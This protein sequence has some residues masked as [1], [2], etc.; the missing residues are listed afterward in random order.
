[1]VTQETII[2]LALFV[3]AVLM[4]GFFAFIYSLKR[5]SYLLLWTAG[6]GLLGLHSLSPVF[7]PWVGLPSWQPALNQWL[8]GVAA[9]LFLCAAQLYAQIAPCV[10]KASGAAVL[11]G[12][13]AVSH[14]LGWI[15]VSPYLGVA[16]VF[17]GVALVFWQERRKQE[18]LADLLL[19]GSFLGWGVMVL[20]TPVW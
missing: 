17:F 10:W 12:I 20:A 5:Q 6:W 16:F 7:E 19:A 1:V 4:A 9:L 14:Y 11:F 8:L 18:S 2:A 3:A 13:W 15:R